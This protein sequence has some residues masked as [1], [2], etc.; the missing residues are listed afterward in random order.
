MIKKVL[1]SL[2]SHFT[3][4]HSI[5][6][7]SESD[8]SDSTKTLFDMILS[9]GINNKYRIFWCVKDVEFF[10]NQYNFK[11]VYFIKKGKIGFAE[12]IIYTLAKYSIYTHTFVGNP[13]NTNQVRVFV[14]HASMPIKNSGGWF[15]NDP[16][17]HS[18]ILGVSEECIKFRK[19]VLGDSDNYVITGLPRNDDLF[20]TNPRVA[21]LANNRPFIV[22]MPTFKH[23]EHSTRNDYGVERNNDISLLTKDNMSIIN[24]RC[25]EYN[26]SLIIKL[27]PSQD[28]NFVEF[29]NLSNIRTITNDSLEK[30]GINV[31]S[32]LGQS[33]ALITD[34]SSVFVDYLL[35]DKPIAFELS[36]RTLYEKGIGYVMDNPEDYMPGARI[37]SVD[38]F[39]NFIDDVHNGVD[40]FKMERKTLKHRLHTYTDDKSSERVLRF[41]GILEE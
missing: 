33:N 17:I 38:S 7:E 6:L 12:K 40:G 14:T 39:L 37:E 9:K 5:M 36:D 35:L 28:L 25:K 18:Y 27:H 11:N 13:N 10:R 30:E 4:K 23:H 2:L 22:W 29:C 16:L 1:Y 26:V 41:L 19:K 24:E 34:F 15:G 20:H 21:E 31:Y 32:L 3:W 8:F